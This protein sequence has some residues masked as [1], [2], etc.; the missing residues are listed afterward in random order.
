L[1]TS[2]WLNLLFLGFLVSPPSFSIELFA[3][4]HWIL[5]FWLK[6]KAKEVCLLSFY[7]I[8]KEKNENFAS[9]FHS[10]SVFVHS[11]KSLFFFGISWTLIWYLAFKIFSIWKVKVSCFWVF[12]Y[13]KK[14]HIFSPSRT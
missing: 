6:S 14:K 3:K 5:S 1:K 2:L 9:Y 8:W 4:F 13:I 11:W 7:A 12:I 10:W